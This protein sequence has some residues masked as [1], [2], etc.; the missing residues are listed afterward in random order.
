MLDGDTPGESEWDN[1]K[2]AEDTAGFQ[3]HDASLGTGRGR[4]RKSSTPKRF[5]GMRRFL[6]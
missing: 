5:D 3:N 6:L 4:I 1:A 2:E